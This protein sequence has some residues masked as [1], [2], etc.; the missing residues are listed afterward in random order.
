[1]YHQ[2]TTKNKKYI[3]IDKNVKDKTHKN[4]KITTIHKIIKK[5]KC[6]FCDSHHLHQTKM[7]SKYIKNSLFLENLFFYISIF[8]DTFCLSGALMIHFKIKL[9]ILYF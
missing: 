9:K 8:F 1:M 7:I 3:K 5:Y 6:I 2:C 4:I